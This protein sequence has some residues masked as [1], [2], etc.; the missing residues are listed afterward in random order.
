MH[1][2]CLRTFAALCRY[3]NRIVLSPIS[4][5]RFD[6]FPDL[7]LLPRRQV[8]G[9]HARGRIASSF[10]VCRLQGVGSRQGAGIR[11]VGPS[12]SRSRF[13]AGELDDAKVVHVASCAVGFLQ[14]AESWEKN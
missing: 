8:A 7:G 4:L 1:R 9:R 12:G 11:N 5:Q 14:S 3:R 2:A 13:G 10:P 6:F